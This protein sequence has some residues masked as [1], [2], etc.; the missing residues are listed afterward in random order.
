YHHLLAQ[1]PGLGLLLR[2]SV[3]YLRSRRAHCPRR[4]W[5]ISCRWRGRRVVKIGL[6]GE[7]LVLALCP[8]EALQSIGAV[9]HLDDDA[10]PTPRAWRT[11]PKIYV[12][13]PH[14]G[15]IANTICFVGR[16]HEI[17]RGCRRRPVVLDH[18]MFSVASATL[19]TLASSVLERHLPPLA[20]QLA[21]LEYLLVCARARNGGY[22]V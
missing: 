22:L 17:S 15:D 6:G 19:R 14:E 7:V 1:R 5:L 2:A 20:N 3:C 8:F 4:C 13:L 18:A 12:S 10:A 11:V 21:Y 9:R 16:R